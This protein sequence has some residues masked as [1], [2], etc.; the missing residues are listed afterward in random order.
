MNLA[1]KKLEIPVTK[2][3]IRVVCCKRCFYAKKDRCRCKCHKVFHGLGRLNK[4]SMEK[5]ENKQPT[6]ASILE[7]LKDNK[8]IWTKNDS[9]ITLLNFFEKPLPCEECYEKLHAYH[10]KIQ[11]GEV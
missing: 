9:E 10:I 7:A 4:R 6:I 5:P 8:I 3:E 11:K 2:E 1:G